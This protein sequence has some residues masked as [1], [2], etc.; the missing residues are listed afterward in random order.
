MHLSR[1][2]IV[3]APVPASGLDLLRCS[4]YY[5]FASGAASQLYRD[6]TRSRD[7]ASTYSLFHWQMMRVHKLFLQSKLGPNTLSTFAVRRSA[8]LLGNHHDIFFPLLHIP[9]CIFKGN[10]VLIHVATEDDTSFPGKESEKP[11]RNQLTASLRY[12]KE[13]YGAGSIRFSAV[14][15]LLISNSCFPLSS[16]YTPCSN[17]SPF[18]SLEN[19]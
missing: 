19:L 18:P 14:N 8:L 11:T 12:S 7:I 13:T 1:L 15:H 9:L 3:V 4:L 2:V 5:V 10:D 6:T 16:R 17:V